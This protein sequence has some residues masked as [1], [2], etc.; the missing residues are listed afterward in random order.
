MKSLGILISGVAHEINNPNNFI[1]INVVLLQKMWED[2]KPLFYERIEREPDFKLGNIPGDKLEESVD[3]VITLKGNSISLSMFKRVYSWFMAAAN[4]EAT[5]LNMCEDG[6]SLEEASLVLNNSV[7]V[8]FVCTGTYGTF[9]KL[10]HTGIIA[11][12]LTLIN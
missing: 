1:N 9:K 12:L 6:A 4:T 11:T 10:S 2:L 3:D 7:K 8:E 5:Y